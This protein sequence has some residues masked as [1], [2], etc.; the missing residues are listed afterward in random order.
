LVNGENV[1]STPGA[2]TTSTV[3]CVVARPFGLVFEIGCTLARA[4]TVWLFQFT[5]IELFNSIAA[6]AQKLV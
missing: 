6:T 5:A 4:K 2:A 3:Y 1:R